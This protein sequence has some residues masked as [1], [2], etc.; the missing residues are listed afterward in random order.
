MRLRQILT[1]LIGNA[2]K[3]TERGE[4]RI[5]VRCTRETDG[6][7]HMQFAISDTGIGIPADKIG[8]LFQPFMQVDG[9]ATRRYGGTGLGLAISRR[10]AKALGG[11]MEVTSRVGQGKHLHPDDRCR[12]AEGRTH[13]AIAPSPI[14]RRGRT[15]F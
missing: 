5:T 11:D 7:G 10:L 2:V 14:D 8:E 1:N 12:L 6:S 13:A 4:V 9:S 15:V 3:F